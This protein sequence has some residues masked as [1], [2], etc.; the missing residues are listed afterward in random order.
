[1]KPAAPTASDPGLLFDW[2][3]RRKPFLRPI[4]FLILSFAVHGMFFYLLRVSRPDRATAA[5]PEAWVTFLDPSE[6]QVQPLLEQIADRLV[7]FDTSVRSDGTGIEISRYTANFRPSFVERKLETRSLDENGVEAPLPGLFA[8]GETTLPATPAPAGRA[9]LSMTHPAGRD[10]VRIERGGGL[11]GR[12]IVEY[13]DWKRSLMKDFSDNRAS[14][15]VGVAADGRVRSCLVLQTGDP[16]AEPLV[17][18]WVGALR[19]APGP[20]ADAVGALQWGK[21]DVWW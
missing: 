16:T 18:R 7:T 20:F 8:G 15:L 1:M 12:E 5:R 13:P 4:G 2:K 19:F 10:I 21:V 14:C 3:S 9:E 6:E 11:A 17:I